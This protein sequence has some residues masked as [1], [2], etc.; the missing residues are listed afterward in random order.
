MMS[1]QTG[2]TTLAELLSAVTEAAAQ[3]ALDNDTEYT[4]DDVLKYELVLW[5]GGRQER[6]ALVIEALGLAEGAVILQT[7]L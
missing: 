5:D 3:W 6:R 2:R 1:Y 4:F 7:T